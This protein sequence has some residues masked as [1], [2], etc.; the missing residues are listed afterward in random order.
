MITVFDFP[1]LQISEQVFY[2]PGQAISGGFTVGGARIS[3]PEPGGY[4]VLE[5]TPS[6]HIHE[7]GTP[8]HSW[9]MSKTNGEVF[10]IPLTC[11]PQ[12]VSDPN[13]D[14]FNPICPW[15]DGSSFGDGTYWEN[16]PMEFSSVFVGNFEPG[17]NKISIRNNTL[18]GFLHVGHVIGHGDYCY[19]VDQ[20]EVVGTVSNLTIK[21]PLRTPILSGQSV[22]FKP[23]F[24]GAI[25]NASE[26]R[27]SYAIANNRHH[28]LQNIIFDEVVL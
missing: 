15:D 12:V 6:L 26:I 9:I 24:T 11:T 25:R 20:I 8:W 17:V 27:S 14:P 4:G 13:H 7:V 2:V 5:V 28:A 16:L 18:N 22:N 19:V 23:V 3:S 21:P 1:D 10:R